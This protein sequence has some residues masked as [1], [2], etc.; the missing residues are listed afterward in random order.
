MWYWGENGRAHVGQVIVVGAEDK[1]AAQ[2]MGWEC[3]S[4]MDEALEMAQ[5]HIGRKPSVTL[6]H[7]PPI[8]MADVAGVPE[9]I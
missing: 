5:S 7:I 2:T 9:T 8:N 3:A 6:M 4:S 1:I